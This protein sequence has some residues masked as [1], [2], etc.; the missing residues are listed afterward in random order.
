MVKMMRFAALAAWVSLISA[1]DPIPANLDRFN[2]DQTDL[3]G[4]YSTYG[5]KDW[6]RVRCADLDQ[7]VS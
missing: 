3:S 5:P 1:E 6:I 2:Y 7:C 4:T